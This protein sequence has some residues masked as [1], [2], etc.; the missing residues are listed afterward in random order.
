MNAVRI[1]A[2]VYAV[3]LDGEL[4]VWDPRG[5]ALHRLNPFATRIWSEIA[6]GA[7]PADIASTIAAECSQTTDVIAS[8][9]ERLVEELL[10]DGV[11]EAR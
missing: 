4:L 6:R 9:V 5:E 2:D 8:D 10:A 1:A 3:E 11:L 7:A